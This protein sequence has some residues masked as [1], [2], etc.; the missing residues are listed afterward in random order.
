MNEDK[1]HEKW[2]MAVVWWEDE[3]V[4][5]KNEYKSYYLLLVH[6]DERDFERQVGDG[7][8]KRA[9][10]DIV[11]VTCAT[12]IQEYFIIYRKIKGNAIFMAEDRTRKNWLKPST[13]TPPDGSK[14]DKFRRGKD[15]EDKRSKLGGFVSS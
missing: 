12:N 15:E 2:L 3:T 11:T 1:W 13:K 6:F 9:K 7:V 4:Q 5:K 14:I 8:V 10:R